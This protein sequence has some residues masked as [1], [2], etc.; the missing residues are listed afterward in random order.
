MPPSIPNNLIFLHHTKISQACI[1]CGSRIPVGAPSWWA[2]F[3]KQLVCTSCKPAPSVSSSAIKSTP[4]PPA[5]LSVADPAQLAWTALVDYHRLCVQQ[6]A[7]AELID[8]GAWSR[9]LIHSAHREEL[10]VGTAD[11]IPVTRALRELASR[12]GPGEVLQYGWPTIVVE[13]ARGGLKVA[14]LLV[15]ELESLGK[16]DTEICPAEDAAN[17]NPALL[18]GY[19]LDPSDVDEL[20]TTLAGPLPAASPAAM[21]QLLESLAGRIGFPCAPL[22]PECLTD[23][24][25]QAVGVHNVAMIIAT[26]S[27]NMTRTL[28]KELGE[29]RHRTDWHQTAARH[30]VPLPAQGSPPTLHPALDVP[31]ASPWPLNDAQEQAVLQM[32]DRKLTVITGPPGTGK[33]QVV[34]AAVANAWLLG[35]TVLLASTN[36][37]AVDVAVSRAARELPGLLLRT[38]NKPNRDKLPELIHT[39]LAQ[40]KAFSGSAAS[41]SKVLHES[42]R[43]RAALL[44]KLAE[45]SRIERMLTEQLLASE[46]SAKRIWGITNSPLPLDA[47]QVYRRARRLVHAWFFRQWRTRRLFKAIEAPPSTDLTTV[48]EWAENLA[49]FELWRPRLLKLQASLPDASSALKSAEDAWQSASSDAAEAAVSTHVAAKHASLTP[50]GGSPKNNAAFAAAMEHALKCAR[51]WACTALSMAQNFPLKAGLFDQVIIDEA[52]QCAVAVALPLAYRAKRLAVVGDPNQLTPIV[53]LATPQ[54]D[55]LARQAGVDRQKLRQLGQDAIDGSTFLAF[56]EAIGPDHVLLLDEHYRCHPRIARWFNQAFYSDALTVLT[57][58]SQMPSDRRGMG[59]TDVSGS[60]TRGRAG[61]WVNQAEAVE[62]LRVLGP[63]LESGRSVGVVTPFSAQAS[64]IRDLANSRFPAGVMSAADFTCGTAHRLQGDERDVIVFSAVVAPGLASRTA[65]WVELSR[66]LLNVAASRARHHLIILGHPTAPTEM[67]IPTLAAL[68][69][70]AMT[71]ESPDAN[72]WG[73]ASLAEARLLDVM[74]AAGLAPLLKPIAE[75][76]ELDFAILRQGSF[77]LDIEVDGA[78][79]LDVRGRQRRRDLARDRILKAEGWL[80]LRFADW[81]CLHEPAA[82]LR[83]IQSALPSRATV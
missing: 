24:L 67:N 26:E 5:A 33:S 18:G 2:K 39:V 52:S 38:G 48:V 51:G 4:G 78:Q 1:A 6:E 21:A 7:A 71:P 62:V 53:K 35:R 59:W 75:G 61:S 57:D 34:V 3:K 68:R 44:E 55:R 9:V 28:L 15:I 66:N 41:A 63:L 17:L 25:P 69:A 82:V 83:E 72:G 36:N 20:S 81:R 56:R 40:A 70:A 12:L 54:A 65:R 16:D 73:T 64:L 43:T 30:L 42:S 58:I 46:S 76:F 8:F 80:V 27:S 60:A 77:K 32:R 14:P 31:M 10:V 11:S 22:A 74:Y 37:A 49:A 45:I 13:D 29:L 19:G 79:H 50:L 23:S 47:R